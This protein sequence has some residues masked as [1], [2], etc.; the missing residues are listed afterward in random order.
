MCDAREGGTVRTLPVVYQA[1]FSC[2]MLAC[3]LTALLPERG[4]CQIRPIQLEGFVITGA[5][6]PRTQGT[7]ASHV[8]VLEGRELRGRGLTSVLE[9]LSEV[10]GLVVVQ[11][12]SYGAVT[13]VLFRGAESDHVKVIVDGVE[14]NQP[15]GAFDF[16]GLL[17]A[18]VE[19]I[20]VVRGPASALYGSDA[21]AGVIHI[22]SKSGRGAVG[23]Y[24]SSGG[25]TYGRLSLGGGL[26]GGTDLLGY[27]LAVARESSDGI[28]AFNNN[29]RNTV[30]SGR[31]SRAPQGP[32]RFHLAGRYSDR[33][34][35]FPTDGGGNVV[36]RNSFSFGREV[37]VAAGVARALSRSLEVTASL[38]EYRWDG[39]SDDRPDGLADTLGFFGF[40]SDDSFRRHTGEVRADL[41]L[42][43]SARISFGFEL[44]KEVAA[45][46]SESFS[47]WGSSSGNDRWER[48]NRGYYG[49]AVVETSGWAGNLGARVDENDHF[50]SFF[51]YQVGVSYSLPQKGIRFRGSIGRGLK[52]PTFVETSSSGYSVGNPALEPERAQ[53]WEVGVVQT[54]LPSG[55]TGSLT[56]FD[57]RLR[58]LIQ[59]TPSS[60]EPGGPNFFNVA[61]A[62]I[63]G[64]EA[65]LSVPLGDMTLSGGYT[66][67]D[68]R[69]LDAG[70]DEGEGAVFVE[71]QP[72]I[73]RPKHQGNVAAGRSFPWGALRGD[74]QWTGSRLDRDFSAWPALPVDLSP[75]LL[76]GLFCEM[77]LVRSEGGDPRLTLTMRADNLLDQDYQGVFGF[78][79]PGRTFLVGLRMDFGR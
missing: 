72:L 6:V 52:E 69:V 63:Q 42:W 43:S 31:I 26:H 48:W 51:T 18:D 15:G 30:V 57:Q 59:Y 22:I 16:S 35:H 33:T 28:L 23:G 75:Y 73:R 64:I 60:P 19:R 3:V 66:Y 56:W 39:G 4:F 47:Q 70:F 79:S 45:S 37:S 55:W 11:Q 9:A 46:V 74:L 21:M 49:H 17:L 44:E 54:H 76:L 24:V 40:V 34:Y 36:D 14:M 29:S 5:P 1:L 2:A 41:G 27:S 53:V 20:E 65:V 8:T 25:G 61:R 13:S 12:G 68:S 77:G 71:G 32:N 50:G 78:E 10:P 58:D 62:R 7:E 67:L 38:R